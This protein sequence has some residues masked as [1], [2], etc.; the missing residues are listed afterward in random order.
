MGRPRAPIWVTL[1]KWGRGLNR[2]IKVLGVQ[3]SWCIR[4]Q[5]FSRRFFF[6]W[7]T[8]FVVFSGGVE[9][10]LGG[11]MARSSCEIRQNKGWEAR[12]FGLAGMTPPPAPTAAKTDLDVLG[13]F[14]KRLTYDRLIYIWYYMDRENH[15]L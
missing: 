14:W 5:A 11:L 6:D 3:S 7:N 13:L 4:P 15:V 9:R 8:H 12:R 1:S 2:E 10:G